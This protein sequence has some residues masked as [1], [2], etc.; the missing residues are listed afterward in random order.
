MGACSMWG[1]LVPLA[2]VL[3]L[4]TPLGVTGI[5]IA[6]VCDEWLR[7]MMMYWRWRRRGWLKHAQ[8][9]HENVAALASPELAESA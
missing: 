6:F 5:W 4:W 2:G 3:A 8:R 9:S 7:A 1:L